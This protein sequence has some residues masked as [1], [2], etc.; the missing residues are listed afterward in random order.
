M[1]NSDFS[2]AGFLTRFYLRRDWLKIVFWL[3][4]LVGLM[5]AAAGKFDGLYG[6]KSAMNSIVTTLKTPAMVAMFGPFTANPPYN[7]ALIFATE[8]MVFMG[9]FMAMMNI[10][11]AV[12]STRAEEDSGILELVRAHC[13]GKYAPLLAATIELLIINLITGV[14][15]TLS[16]IAANMTGADNTGS[17]IFGLGLAAVGFMFGG[18]TLLMAQ[19]SDNSRGATMLSYLILALLFLVRMMTDV[20]NPDYTWWSPFGWI[21]K[22]SVYDENIWWPVFAMLGVAILT[23]GVAFYAYA[24]RDVTA[25]LLAT[26]PG[27]T[28]ASALL[29]GPF[30]LIFRLE[31]T[32]FIVWM[33]GMFVLGASY[34]SIFSTVGDIMKTNPMMAKLMGGSAVDAANQTVILNF[35]ALLSIVF[36]VL[37]TVPAMQTVLKL[38]TDERKGWLEQIHAK[39]ISRLH[40][41][42]SYVAVALI[43]GTLGLLLGI[44]GM[45][46]AG[47]SV[48]D[49]PIPLD[50]FLRA[51]Y[52]FLPAQLVTIGISALLMGVVPR[53]QAIS[54]IVPIYGFISL[55]L[56]GLLDLPKW[57]THLTPYGW[58]NKVPLRA[59]Q[60][61]LT[62]E[63]VLIAVVLFV[64]GFIFYKRRDMVEN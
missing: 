63:L 31:R 23:V 53:I 30:T 34:G 64:L 25:G 49:A 3:I 56:G 61:N 16:L 8:M 50:R 7:S 36:V 37:S 43:T 52:G 1:H 47:Q 33:I 6:T 45:Y 28:R 14:L 12:K 27:R 48:M 17:L 32:S 15:E 39:S 38:N 19:L 2:Q 60:W 58:V 46:T 21:E 51:F 55:Y 5:G 29:A 9:L 54:W 40:L 35:A 11:F 44:L 26:R 20:S 59:V 57:A 13:V 41:Y 10:Y 22:L 42:C 62:W 24:R 4:G 18:F